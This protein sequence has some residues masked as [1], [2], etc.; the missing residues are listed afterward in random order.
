MG[1]F[2]PVHAKSVAFDILHAHCLLAAAIPLERHE[3]AQSL[4]QRSLAKTCTKADIARDCAAPSW[5][6]PVANR[7]TATE[8]LT[9]KT[10]NGLLQQNLPSA[11]IR[12][13]PSCG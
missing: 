5:P 8:S 9:K 13:L 7:F 11:D 4:S 3:E 12:A 1:W 10:C 2:R 6:V